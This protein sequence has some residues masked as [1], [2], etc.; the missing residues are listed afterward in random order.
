VSQN[1][2]PGSAAATGPR[3]IGRSIDVLAKRRIYTAVEKQE[4]GFGTVDNNRDAAGS[5]RTSRFRDVTVLIALAS[6][7]VAVIYNGIQ[8]SN[9]ADQ[10]EQGQRSLELSSRANQL[11]T[12]MNMHDRIVRANAETDKSSVAVCRAVRCSGELEA[13]NAKLRVLDAITP[14]EGVV[15]A[16]E[17]EALPAGTEE[18]WTNYAVCDY[19]T[20]KEVLGDLADWVPNLA[21]FAERHPVPQDQCPIQ[22]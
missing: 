2:R 8:V 15:F 13:D 12:F 14:L 16:L 10:L 5:G 11:A 20:A 3:S 1:L 7:L 19:Q 21:D 17:H 22:F 6:L 4:D 9:T 18:V